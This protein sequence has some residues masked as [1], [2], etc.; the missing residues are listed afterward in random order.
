MLQQG[1]LK[2][3]RKEA[4]RLRIEV[5]GIS[6]MHWTGNGKVVTLDGW[7]HLKDQE[8]TRVMRE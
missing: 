7:E 5:L 2:V 3:I 8:A 6:E 4:V 1:K